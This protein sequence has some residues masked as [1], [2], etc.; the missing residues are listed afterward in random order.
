M[1]IGLLNTPS[2]FLKIE[3]ADINVEVIIAAIK[4]FWVDGSTHHSH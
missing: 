1:S 2:I 3:V 4:K